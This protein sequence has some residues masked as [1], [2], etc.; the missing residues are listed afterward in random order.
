[1]NFSQ[2]LY[3]CTLKIKYLLWSR[4]YD[5]FVTVKFARAEQNY[6]DQRSTALHRWTCLVDVLRHVNKITRKLFFEIR[7]SM[8]KHRRANTNRKSK[9]MIIKQKESNWKPVLPTILN[10]DLVGKTLACW[11]TSNGTVSKMCSCCNCKISLNYLR[12]HQ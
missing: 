1:M 5:K 8:I 7:W 10:C 12:Q 6:L 9:T 4:I 11:S 3:Q 2:H